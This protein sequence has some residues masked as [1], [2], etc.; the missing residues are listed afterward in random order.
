MMADFLNQLRT[1]PRLRMGL[2]LIIAIAWLYGVL[3]LRDE[4]KAQNQRFRASNLAIGRLQAQ[5]AEPEWTS[6]A[7]A[8]RALAV[9]LESKLWQAPTPGLAQAA[10]QDW[11]TITMVKAGI[12]SPQV[13]VSVVEEAAGSNAGAPADATATPD[14]LADLWKLKAKLYFEFNPPA[15]MDFLATMEN[16][17][18]QTVVR[19]LTIR[20]EP[21]PRVEMELIAYFQKQKPANGATGTP[22]AMPP[23]APK[24][25]GAKP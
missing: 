4:V 16:N 11:V 7:P 10:Y 21:T 6:R 1:N 20:K 14:A 2:V 25:P 24:L 13:T 23:S 8:A 22:A 18:R 5:L 12:T 17:D 9:Q 3:T 19:T 15:L